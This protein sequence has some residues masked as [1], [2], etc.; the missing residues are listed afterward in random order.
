MQKNNQKLAVE[1]WD[2][3]FD[4]TKFQEKCDYDDFEITNI[5]Y[6]DDQGIVRKS[7]QY[8]GDTLGYIITERLDR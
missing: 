7:S 2:V 1:I 8:H 6:V 4:V 5:Y 3:K